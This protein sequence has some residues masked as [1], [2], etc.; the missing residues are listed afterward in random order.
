MARPR[1]NPIT[2]DKICP[3]CLKQFTISSRKYRQIF[4]SK[5]C[6]NRHPDVLEKMKQNQNKTFNK[7]YG[8]HP[9]K[10]KKTIEKF[11]KS[12]FENHGNDYFTN[13]LVRESKKTNLERYGNE[14][15]NN[16]EK[17]KSTMMKLYGVENYVYTN[18]Y[19][20]K[21]KESCLKR[22]GVEYS[23]QSDQYKESMKQLMMK[24]FLLGE[25]FKNF[26]PLFSI[27]EYVGVTKDVSRYKFKCNRCGD[28]SLHNLGNGYRPSCINC[29]K[30]QSS[31]IQKEI[32]DFIKIVLGNDTV[33]LA[34]NKIEI[35]PK[36]LDI[37]IPSSKIGIEFNGLF[38]HSE[39]TGNKNKVYHLNK[40]NSCI[41]K[42]IRLIHIFENEWLYQKDIVKSILKNTLN[43]TPNK[44][45]ARNCE[46]KEVNDKESEVFLNENH[47]QKSDRSTIKLGLY[48]NNNLV[49]IMT[50]AISRF[51]KKYQYEMIRFCNKINTSVIGG[52]N[53][54]FSYF[55]NAYNPTSVVSY[56]DRRYFSG[57]VYQ[58]LGFKFE[59]NTPPN[60]FYIINNYK[61]LKSRMNFQKYK[62]KNILTVFDKKLTEWENMKNNG[63]DRIWDCGHSKWVLRTK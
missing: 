27:D 52:A 7:K 4:C 23:S 34:N 59:R 42:G 26:T 60:Y 16:Q 48:H 63:F 56:S 54:L 24:K 44:I 41:F 51:D 14:N 11:K 8:G 25:D 17:M 36:E 58:N 9:M 21:R 62:L 37:Y 38:W 55:V 49:S 6:A 19:K 35:Y 45:Y 33:V 20:E 47:I 32:Y 31:F 50:F 53:K 22:Y 5:S 61:E 57:N 2:I 10:T 43:K 28:I 12:L 29:D 40:T 39:I 1:K 46:I 13:Y 15:Y 3:T 30:L 18:E